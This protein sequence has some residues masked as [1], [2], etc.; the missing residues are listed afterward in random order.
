M[1]SDGLFLAVKCEGASPMDVAKKVKDYLS[2]DV[3][4][5]GL[6]DLVL[7][8]EELRKF[9]EFGRGLRVLRQSAWEMLISF[10]LSQRSNIG[11]IKKNIERLCLRYGDVL[12][13]RDAGIVFSG[14][15]SIEQLEGVKASDLREHV[16][17]GY[18]AEY[19]VSAVEQVVRNDVLNKIVG[20]KYEDQVYALMS[21]IKGVG[22]KV[23]DCVV[24]FGLHN[25]KAFPIDVWIE[26]V[27]SKDFCGWIDVKS[28]GNLAGVVQQ[29]LYFYAITHKDQYVEI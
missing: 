22:R 25:A 26:R 29:L 10:I 6:N 27:V 18:R 11:A 4:Y 13:D 16:H 24:L 15:P 2:L 21:S 7:G 1:E 8:C 12:S 17:C 19:V 23:A 20:E 5:G 3:D 28:F 9:V 14:F